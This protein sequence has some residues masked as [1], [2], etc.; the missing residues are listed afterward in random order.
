MAET[1]AATAEAA[2]T[3]AATADD[4]THLRWTITRLAAGQSGRAVYSAVVR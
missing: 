2:T 1:G 4:V 3:G